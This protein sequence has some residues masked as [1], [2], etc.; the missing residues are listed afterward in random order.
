M[1]GDCAHFAESMVPG[2]LDFLRRVAL[3]P[4]EHMLDVGCGAGQ[5]AIPAASA[6]VRVTGI[7]IAANLIERATTRARAEGLSAR[8]DEGG[9]GRR[10]ITVSRRRH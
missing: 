3:A 4:G 1:D 5:I 10:A 8:F 7:D 9:T 2:A 6:G